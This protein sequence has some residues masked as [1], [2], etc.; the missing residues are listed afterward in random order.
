MPDQSGNPAAA[1]RRLGETVKRRRMEQGIRSMA[2]WSALVG[3]SSR[4]LLGLERG[5]PVGPDTLSAV[6]VVLGWDA[7]R[8]S[9]ILH[10]AAEA[11][12]RTATRTR[13]RDM[14][15]QNGATIRALR[16]KDGYTTEAFA[17][18]VGVSYSHYRNI[19]SGRRMTS[20]ELLNR[21]AQA[22]A[23]PLAAIL[24]DPADE[25][26][27]P[28]PAARPSA[29]PK[30]TVTRPAIDTPWLITAEAAQYARCSEDEIRDAL[31]SGELHG[32][33]RRPGG[34]WRIHRDWLDA[35]LRGDAAPVVVPLVTRRGQ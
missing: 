10:D 21:I 7:G 24:R 20:P 28:A 15:E 35:W 9:V 13:S 32:T 25:A 34:R 1:W 23:V 30:P 33:Q 14:I 26:P 27:P 31:A 3:R 2:D 4:V 18:Q 19:E 5:E 6:E 29:Q 8:A 11:P 17:E 12:V 16:Q 22:L